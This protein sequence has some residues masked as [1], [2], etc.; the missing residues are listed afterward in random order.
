M[1]IRP[2]LRRSHGS[3]WEKNGKTN[4]YIIRS[5]LG[6][7]EGEKNLGVRRSSGFE[8]NSEK[9]GAQN[10]FLEV[11]SGGKQLSPLVLKLLSTQVNASL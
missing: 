9:T 2:K 1:S 3:H 5:S 8:W 4:A 6:V 10:E 11:N 7:R